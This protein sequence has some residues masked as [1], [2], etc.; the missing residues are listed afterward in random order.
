MS[1]EPK[2]TTRCTADAPC[3]TG[4]P[5]PSTMLGPE[6]RKAAHAGHG[7]FAPTVEQHAARWQD[8]YVDGLEKAKRADHFI[9]AKVYRKSLGKNAEGEETFF[10]GEYVGNRRKVLHNDASPQEVGSTWSIYLQEDPELDTPVVCYRL[11][12]LEPIYGTKVVKADDYDADRTGLLAYYKEVLA[13]KPKLGTPVV[14]PELGG[15][16]V[17]RVTGTGES[18]Y[19][20]I[21]FGWED[22]TVGPTPGTSVRRV[23]PAPNDD[24]YY[25][26]GD[27]IDLDD[28]DLD[29]VSEGS[30][31]VEY[32]NGKAGIFSIEDFYKEFRLCTESSSSNFYESYNL[33]R[34]P[35]MLTPV[36]RNLTKDVRT[37]DQRIMGLDS[38]SSVAFSAL[39]ARNTPDSGH[40]VHRS[41][42]ETRPWSP[43]STFRWHREREAPPKNEDFAPLV[44]RPEK[45]IRPK[46]GWSHDRLNAVRAKMALEAGEAR[47]A[48]H[49]PARLPGSI[50]DR[51]DVPAV[52]AED[53]G[54]H[55]D[56]LTQDY[57]GSIIR[58]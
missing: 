57:N 50:W 35:V 33:D 11:N 16:V 19:A 18:W 21:V 55:E 24:F 17:V 43:D 37:S 42:A 32:E 30:I 22:T 46:K 49:Q 45:V 44:G 23:M 5:P 8:N 15:G 34:G 20:N 6:Y 7:E 51:L 29:K 1:K 14:N 56:L 58:F 12:L 31:K 38:R 10:V 48:P 40:F 26:Y 13:P 4:K 39:N 47:E 36:F 27:V 28:D 54:E 41:D 3:P 9:V 52:E 53:E 25:V 2:G